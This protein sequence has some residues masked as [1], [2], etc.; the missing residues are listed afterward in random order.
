M[1]ILT[2]VRLLAKC[3]MEQRGGFWIRRLIEKQLMDLSVLGLLRHFVGMVTDSRSFLSFTR[4]EYYRRIACDF[5][6]KQVEM[7]L[8]PNEKQIINP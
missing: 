7:G 8:I 6:G 5:I 2:T 4:H 1:A 3:N